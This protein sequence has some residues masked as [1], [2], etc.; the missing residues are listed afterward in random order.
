MSRQI[1]KIKKGFTLVELLV[2][3]TIIAL[4]AGLGGYA[5]IA[6]R[7]SVIEGM[8]KAELDGGGL[9]MKLQDYHNKYGEY[10]PDFSDFVGD[11]SANDGKAVMRHIRKRWPRASFSDT[12]DVKNKMLAS[13]WD[14]TDPNFKHGGALVFWLG[15]FPD[16]KNN[17][18]CLAGFSAD[19]SAPLTAFKNNGDSIQRTPPMMEFNYGKNIQTDSTGKK[20][21]CY[22]IDELPVAYF[23]SDASGNY[24]TVNTGVGNPTNVPK[25]VD[26][27]FDGSTSVCGI[28]VPYAKTNSGSTQWYSPKKYQ[29]VHPGRDEKFSKDGATTTDIR[30]TDDDSTLGYEDLD[31]IINFSE[32]PRLDSLM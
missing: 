17:P 22:I 25:H 27:K 6:A 2:V 8:I 12:S 11:G 20:P 29:L 24:S 32:K 26:F 13:G 19:E 7:G 9:G 4:L 18:T 28:A 5:I 10:P 16:D 14:I 30:T 21:L 23:V 15:G 31:N 1:H 3:I